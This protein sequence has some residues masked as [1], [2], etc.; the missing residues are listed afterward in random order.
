MAGYYDCV[1]YALVAFG[2]YTHWQGSRSPVA[3][4]VCLKH[5][6]VALREL[7]KEI[8]H[9]NSS[10][11]DAIICSSIFLAGTAQDWWVNLY[12]TSIRVDTDI[13]DG[14]R[15][16]WGIFIDGYSNVCR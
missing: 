6:T 15:E 7:Q 8:E 16:S 5:Y 14:N 3:E 2:A 10:N 13:Q 11:A 4:D 12:W 9:F 1:K